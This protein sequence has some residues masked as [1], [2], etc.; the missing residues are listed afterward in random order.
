M[1]YLWTPWRYQ[2]MAKAAS[3]EPPECIF[4]DAVAKK[5]DS[6]TLIV[7]LGAKAFGIVNRFPYTSG[8]VMIVPYAHV[9]ELKLC[10][11]AT[12]SEIMQLA[13]RVEGVYRASYKPD[14]MKDRK[15]TRLNSSHR[16]ISYAVFCLK[17]KR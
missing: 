15:S 13:Q 12:L 14:G 6:E 4:C 11:A 7:H 8:H 3:G 2:Y 1:D 10:D 5:R 9:A 17:K 16:T